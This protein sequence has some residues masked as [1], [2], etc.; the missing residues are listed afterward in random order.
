MPRKVLRLVR[1][2]LCLPLAFAMTAG[3]A[4]YADPGCQGPC[5]C[6]PHYYWWQ[7]GP[8]RIKIKRACPR[9]IC[10]PCQLEHWGYYETCWRAWPFPPDWSHCPTPP[11]AAM[12]EGQV[13]MP[14]AVPLQMPRANGNGT[15]EQRVNPEQQ[16]PA[17]R[18]TPNGL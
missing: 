9:P 13:P 7:E 3:P 4:A 10:P 16:L 14:G 1:R 6:P 11:A 12:I 8:P 5:H 2:L 18:R 17:P 15:A